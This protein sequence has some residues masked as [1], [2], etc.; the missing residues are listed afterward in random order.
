[1]TTEAYC[2]C[3]DEITEVATQGFRGLNILL[4]CKTCGMIFIQNGEGE[5]FSTLSFEGVR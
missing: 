5:Q 3:C 2:A 4:R 1:M